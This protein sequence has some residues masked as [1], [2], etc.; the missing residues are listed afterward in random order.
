MNSIT[1][2]SKYS[3]GL[4]ITVSRLAAKLHGY[5]SRYVSGYSEDSRRKGL[6]RGQVERVDWTLTTCLMTVRTQEVNQAPSHDVRVDLAIDY[7]T[8]SESE[9]LAK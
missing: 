3:N 8:N 6:D 5:F 1:E 2:S 4:G 7:N 9:P